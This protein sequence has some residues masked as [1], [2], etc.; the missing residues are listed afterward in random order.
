MPIKVFDHI[1]RP[2]RDDD[3]RAF[4]LMDSTTRYSDLPA[5]YKRYRDDIFDDKYKRL[6]EDDLSRTITAHIAKDGYWYIHPR[7]GR[8]LTVREAARLQTF[9]DWYRFAGPPSAAFEQIGNAVPPLL[10]EHLARAILTSLSAQAKAPMTSDAISRRLSRWFEERPALGQPWLRA[11]NRWQVIAAASVLHRAEPGQ[12]R[13]LWPLI[14]RWTVPADT[15]HQA[16]ELGQ[17]AALIGKERR[18]ES[19]LVLA[20]AVVSTPEVLARPAVESRDIPTLPEHVAQLA[21]LV[22][23]E[24][25]DVEADE[26]VLA[27]GGALRVASR[28]IGEPVD[29]RNRL[30]DGRL[31]IARLVGGGAESRAA[32]LAVLEIAATIC[33]P[34][35]PL[36]RDC[37]LSDVCRTSDAVAQKAQH[38]F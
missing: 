4:E 14:E 5:E 13:F 21:T 24:V 12:V 36:C 34:V 2:V 7:Q 6:N 31:A 27:T 35:A 37:P 18:Y 22:V 3:A 8:T 28:V 29:K 38:L 32:H 15:I 33:R 10:G 26:P 9:P 1:T 23:S 17:I 25:G 30:T 19:L 20:R 11:S 16:Q